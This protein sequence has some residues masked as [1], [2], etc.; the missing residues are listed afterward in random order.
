MGTTIKPNLGSFDEE[1]FRALLSVPNVLVWVMSARGLFEEEQPSL[2]AF[3]GLRFDEIRGTG[4]TR[5]L[6]PDDYDRVLAE[7]NDYQR[8]RIPAEIH[9]RMRRHDGEWRHMRARSVPVLDEQG[10]VREWVGSNEDI[11]GEA[12]A[13]EEMR[14]SE[15][16]LRQFAEA[17][18]HIAWELDREGS[19]VWVNRRFY[20]YC[21]LPVDS[22]LGWAWTRAIHPEDVERYVDELKKAVKD[23]RSSQFLARLRSADAEFRWFQFVSEPQRDPQGAVHRWFGT[24]TDIDDSHQATEKIHRFLATLAHELRNPLAPISNGI[25]IL[26]MPRASEQAQA[27]ALSTIERQTAHVVRLLDDLMDLNRVRSDRLNLRRAPVALSAVINTAV[28]TSRPAIEKGGHTLRVTL[29]PQ[30]LVLDADATR[31]TQVL[32]NVLNNAAKF[33]PPESP[34]DVTVTEDAACACVDIV[35]RGIGMS[36]EMLRRAFDMFAQADPRVERVYGG[37]GIGLNVAKRL[38]EL[39]GG[40]IEAFS[41][42]A[43]RGTRVS[44]RLPLTHAVRVPSPAAEAAPVAANAV[45]RVLVVDDNEDAARITSLLFESLG[46]VVRSASSGA[47]ALEIGEA[48][49]PDMALLDIGMPGMSGYELA[50]RWRRTDWGRATTLVALTG[51]G[52]ESDR[53]RSIEAGFDHHLVKPAGMA[54]LRKL[55]LEPPRNADAAAR[56]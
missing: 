34:I 10:R 44:I 16:R 55:L 12:R 24:A 21:G 19:T 1:R 48:F 43:G 28:E 52:Q 8:A 26:R 32:S 45:R 31:L 3:T 9:Y 41:E 18:P 17:L 29:P 22:G 27:A 23:G 33:S 37:L 15:A 20:D 5:V 14:E 2:Q 40:T 30:A 39:H 51:W 4:W 46:H 6:H 36:P 54:A 7:W 47:E 50:R 13:H 49:R 35:D 11:T 38:V 56:A 42:G 53:Q 25:Q